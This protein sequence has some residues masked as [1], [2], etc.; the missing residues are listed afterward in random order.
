MAACRRD[1]KRS[2]PVTID[3]VLTAARAGDQGYSS[4]LAAA[5]LQRLG[6]R[7]ATDVVGGFQAWRGAE[8]PIA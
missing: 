5:T 4:S 3:H 8:P 7:N 1:E 2:Q 6:L